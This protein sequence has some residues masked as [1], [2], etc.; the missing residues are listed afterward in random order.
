MFKKIRD[1]FYRLVDCIFPKFCIE[2]KKEGEFLCEECF[3]KIRKFKNPEFK[4]IDSGLFKMIII[5]CPFH[6]NPV[7]RKGLHAMKYKFYKEICGIL[8]MLIKEAI[9]GICEL[10][11]AERLIIVPMPLHK[12]RIKFR[13]F[14]QAEELAKH[15]GLPVFNLLIRIKQTK[16]QATLTKTQRMQNIKDAFCINPKIPPD[17]VSKNTTIILLDDVCTTFS[18]IRSAALALQKN[19]FRKIIACA[20]AYAEL[21]QNNRNK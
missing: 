9:N 19:G 5:P 20:A 10:K 15:T 1:F 16:S 18:T 11:A 13:G 2:C 7:L 14:N 12:K 21:H 17:T 3:N 6:K 4:N 8:A